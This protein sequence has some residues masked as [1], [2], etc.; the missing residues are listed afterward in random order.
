VKAAPAPRA[1]VEKAAAAPL[2]P[3]VKSAPAPPSSDEKEVT[4]KIY[5]SIVSF[6]FLFLLSCTFYCC[7]YLMCL[8]YYIAFFQSSG[9][10]R[11]SI[12]ICI[13]CW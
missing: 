7:K 10:L 4:R 13:V 5:A 3:V 12:F 9:E 1:P 11:V 6:Y 8:S 2:T